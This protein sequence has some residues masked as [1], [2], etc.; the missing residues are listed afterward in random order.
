MSH[1]GVAKAVRLRKEV[2]PE[3]YCTDARCLWKL[4]SGSC[5]KHPP[6]PEDYDDGRDDF[7]FAITMDDDEG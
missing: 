6:A 2:H 5:P 3:L 7:G 1:G 4:S